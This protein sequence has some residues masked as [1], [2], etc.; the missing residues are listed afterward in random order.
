M[1]VKVFGRTISAR[2]IHQEGMRYQAL[3]DVGIVNT[4]TFI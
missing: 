1:D 4:L 2:H 3:R